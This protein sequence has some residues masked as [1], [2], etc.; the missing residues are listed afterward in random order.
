MSDYTPSDY[1][2]FLAQ[3]GNIFLVAR[4]DEGVIGFLL[5]HDHEELKGSHDNNYSSLAKHHPAPLFLVNQIAVSKKT[6]RVGV[7]KALYEHAFGLIAKRLD[8]GASSV[9]F[10]AIVSEPRNSA[11][12][13]FHESLGFKPHSCFIKALY[14][15][16][17][18]YARQA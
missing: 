17:T 6:R 8:P 4:D 18:L 11:S 15:R 14:G 9:V 5:A 10:A 16:V 13:R 3:R 12:I 1:E 2:R 7:G